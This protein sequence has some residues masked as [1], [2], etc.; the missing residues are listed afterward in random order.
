VRRTDGYWQ[1]RNK[2]DERGNNT[3]LA[4][5]DVDGKPVLYLGDHAVVR[6]SFDARNN[7]IEEST[8]E[9]DGNPKLNKDG[10]AIAR[11]DYDARD[12]VREMRSYG[13]DAKLV[14]NKSGYAV[15]R[16]EYNTYGEVVHRT[17]LDE[18]ERV[19]SE[20][21]NDVPRAQQ[22][23]VELAA[24]RATK[25]H[26]FHGAVG[27][28]VA[29]LDRRGGA[30]RAGIKIGDLIVLYNRRPIGESSHLYEEVRRPRTGP[31]EVVLVRGGVNVPVKVAPGPM[32]LFP[33]EE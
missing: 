8:F 3:E 9:V 24:L 29:G 10:V 27:V 33:L 14:R 26:L 21:I 31:V 32:G 11:W 20:T 6:R 16:S 7:L 13:L 12:R 22:A 4:A 15:A 28:V 1:V 30:D 5:F 25:P 2:Y 23:R 18:N 19:V 17:L